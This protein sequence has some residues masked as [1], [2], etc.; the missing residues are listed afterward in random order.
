M[1]KIV[2]FLSIILLI[3]SIFNLKNLYSLM[4]KVQKQQIIINELEFEKE[5][6]EYVYIDNEN[7]RY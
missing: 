7:Q 2:M 3:L 4:D 1:N 5:Y 6:M